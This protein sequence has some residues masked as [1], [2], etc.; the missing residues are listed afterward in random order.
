V[1]GSL[2]DL[3]ICTIPHRHGTL[4]E[5]LADLDTQ[6]TALGTPG[7]VGAILYRDNLTVSYG[8]K[9]QALVHASEADYVSCID[10]DDL[11]A[12]DGMRRIVG[13]LAH[14]PDYVGFAVR[15]TKD[16]VPQI[17]VEHSL[18]HP[19]WENGADMLRRSVMHFNPIRREIALA[20]NWSGEHYGAEKRWGDG[21][22]ASGLC[23]NEI[24]LEPPPAYL[25]RNSDADTFKTGRQP[26]PETAIQ[27]VP[28]YP[29]LTILD[30]TGSVLCAV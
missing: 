2:W 19:R 27:P 17:P 30:W 15:W 16:G 25:Y 18:R 9:T 10:D 22:I 26:L 11:L 13:A 12:P 29:W 7:L 20:G 8:D 24:W 28:R 4:C 1:S 3:L 23:R 14:V 21:V 6:I 5:L